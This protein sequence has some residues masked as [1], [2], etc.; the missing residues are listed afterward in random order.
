M[1]LR[2]LEMPLRLLEGAFRLHQ[3]SFQLLKAPYGCSSA[4]GVQQALRPCT[5][6][7]T[8]A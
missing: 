6:R 5:H 4:A 2:L 1:P 8:L 7:C 3:L